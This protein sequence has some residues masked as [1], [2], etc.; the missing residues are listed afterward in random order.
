MEPQLLDTKT[1]PEQSLLKIT[2]SETGSVLSLTSALHEI[3]G[4]DAFCNHISALFDSQLAESI[5]ETLQYAHKR[6]KLI[7]N[8]LSGS[9]ITPEK[10]CVTCS[11]I[12]YPL[13]E[14]GIITLQ[15]DE[16]IKNNEKILHCFFKT[17]VTPLALLDGEG[18]FLQISESFSK[19]FPYPPAL[20]KI[21]LHH[22]LE[23]FH[24][25]QADNAAECMLAAEEY[26]AYEE[27]LTL[28][29]DGAV[30]H[31]NMRLRY[32]RETNAY[33]VTTFDIT[34]QEELYRRLEHSDQLSITGEIAA[35]IAHE[36]RNPMTTLHGF[37]QLLEHKVTGDA[38]KYVTVI[39][40]E[41]IRINEILSEMLTLAKPVVD[42]VTIFSLS[43]LVDDVLTLLRPKALLDQITVICDNRLTEPALIQANPNRMKQV[44]VNL[45][46]NS[47]EAMSA[48]GILTVQLSEQEDGMLQVLV[49]DNGAGMDKEMIETIF[50]PFVSSKQGGTGLGLPFVKKTI[51]EY[52]GSVAVSSELG[53]GTVFCLT[54]PRYTCN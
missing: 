30:C 40:E 3:L 36:V 51:T 5:V 8:R 21:H 2:V 13:R 17:S 53:K 41:V 32:A 49:S 23:R 18:F 35:S 19:C 52:G 16:S 31:F 6:K 38:H 44:L 45:L 27:K 15:I 28:H 20:E 24:R 39:Q 54:I 46:K 26:G 37:L 33:I 10:L 14:K 34:E 9:M 43:V 1:A 47:M 25:T 22:F 11:I 12:Y 7:Q 42:E 48:S 50:S 4:G 29:E